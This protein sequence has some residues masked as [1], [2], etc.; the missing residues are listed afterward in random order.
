MR[1]DSRDCQRN[2][3]CQCRASRLTLGSIP[4]PLSID[5]TS[6]RSRDHPIDGPNVS[7]GDSNSVRYTVNRVMHHVPCSLLL[8]ISNSTP[9]K[10]FDP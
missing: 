3:R 8:S 5:H 2:P 1:E 6:L 9:T 10:M 7:D 4:R